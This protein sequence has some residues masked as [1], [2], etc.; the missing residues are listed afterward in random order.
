M[1]KKKLTNNDALSLIHTLESTVVSRQALLDRLGKSY[2]EDRNLYDAL[3]YR[4]SPT[5]NDYYSRY[6]RQDIAKRII[7]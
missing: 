4:K 2:G 6:K 7:T 5:F 1:Q 3:G